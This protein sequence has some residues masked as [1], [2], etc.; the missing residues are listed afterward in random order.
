MIH[1]IKSRNYNTEFFKCDSQTHLNL[2]MLTHLKMI[3]KN[4]SQKESQKDLQKWFTRMMHRNDSQK[5][6]T[7]N[8]SQK[9]FTKNIQRNYWKKLF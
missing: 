4:Y 7:K 5:L 6:L 8:E 2:E 1:C 3:H 9:L